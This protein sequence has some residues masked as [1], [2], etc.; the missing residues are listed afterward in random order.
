MK[1]LALLTIVVI[2]T[3]SLAWGA[4]EF[5]PW[6]STDTDKSIEYLGMVFGQIGSVL[7]GSGNQLFGA[8]FKAFNIIVLTLGSIVVTHSVLTATLSTA[9]EGDIMGK[10]WSSI[11]LP[12]KAAGGLSLLIPTSTGY[13]LI[14]I[15]MMWIILQGIHGANQLWGL[16]LV[17]A[18]SST[19]ITTSFKVEK[20][21]LITTTQ[22][23]FQ[24]AICMHTVNNNADA[25][26]LMDGDEVSMYPAPNGSE[27]WIG[28]DNP[29]SPYQATCGKI[30]PSAKDPIASN[31]NQ[32]N[33]RQI[34]GGEIA[35]LKM[36]P[37][38]EEAAL[39]PNDPSQWSG[40]SIIAL[41]ADGVKG[42]IVN[43]ELN[44]ANSTSAHAALFEQ[45]RKDGWIHAGTYYH[46]LVKSG[47]KETITPPIFEPPSDSDFI[48]SPLG[49]WD[50]TIKVTANKY[51]LKSDA[52]V[53][54]AT[55]A[56]IFINN[57]SGA[58]GTM[59]SVL[60][61]TAG[62]FT[63]IARDLMAMLSKDGVDPIVSLH[64]FGAEVMR[65]TEILFWSFLIGIPIL[66]AL[67][68]L[69]E[70][71]SPACFPVGIV[72]V[73][74]MPILILLLALLWA[75]GVSLGL[76]VPLIP[77]LI[78][79]FTAVG[80]MILCIETLV[81]APIV[82]LGITSPGQD[83]L[84]KAAPAVMLITNV[85]LRPSLMIIGF[86]AA[87]RLL[88]SIVGMINFGF[89]AFMAQA[90]SGMA[91][92]LFGN[93]A[94]V[95]IYAGVL[96]AVIHQ[97]FSLTY[98]LPDKVIRWIGGQAEQSQVEKL[99]Q[100]AKKSADTAAST[101]GG[102]M[103]GASQGSMEGAKAMQKAGGKEG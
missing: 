24:A 19:G 54:S 103:K 100:E 66:M 49:T 28:V 34:A 10:K 47:N 88:Q 93:L 6:G 26:T 56:S 78:F 64:D 57:P 41:G 97:V 96:V 81:A 76:Y 101:T 20:E 75:A 98:I 18:N 39:F 38:A 46:R 45:A 12:L 62:T 13:S 30:K 60:G 32:W 94:I 25:L 83:Y 52:S 7:L 82:A 55:D 69:M 67:A 68:C 72:V 53:G 15:F 73:I 40:Q 51:L 77:F 91:L 61:G 80:W 2:L 84:G 74:L 63:T 86:I 37:Y 90:F 85:F 87:A 58:N 33:L 99:T 29:S 36:E 3:P 65:V 11:W 71:F 35:I 1:K 14:Q 9:H 44:A 89:E 17:K 27:I 16:V 21:A 95:I 5:L 92:L 23:L 48:L 50:Y 22:G 79:S 59:T 8:L 42:Q 70:M 102:M 4:D 43:F 31:L